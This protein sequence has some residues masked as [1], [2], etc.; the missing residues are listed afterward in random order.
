MATQEGPAVGYVGAVYADTGARAVR[1]YGG[2]PEVVA[3]LVR[4][5]FERLDDPEASV[6]AYA[7]GEDPTFSM[8]VMTP[9]A[10]DGLPGL[11]LS[12]GIPRSLDYLG[13]ILVLDALGLFDALDIRDVT[14][15]RRDG[16]WRLKHGQA[17]LDVSLRELVKLVFGP[18]RSPAS[19]QTYSPSTSTSGA[20]TWASLQGFAFAVETSSRVELPVQ[21]TFGS[22][23]RMGRANGEAVAEPGRELSLCRRR[24]PV[25]LR[26]HGEGL[27]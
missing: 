5:L 16:G 15:E 12:R 26:R 23:A 11:L 1:E 25:R 20:W 10:S 3:G 21:V 24:A 8:A 22:I 13:M 18:E 7:P 19:P 4:A 27:P 14:V 17:T 6:S 9:D 2:E